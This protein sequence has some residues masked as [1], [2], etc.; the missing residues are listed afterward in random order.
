M[1]DLFL[2]SFHTLSHGLVGYVVP[3]LFV[4]TIVVFFHELG[5]FLVAR[6]NGVKV[7]TFSIGFGPEIVGFNDRYGTRWKL[8]AVPLGGYVKFFGD[9]SEASTPSGDALSQM[10]ASERAVSFHHKPVGPRAAIV[11]AGPLANFILAVVLFTFLFSVFG[12]PNT[13][14]R[15]DGVQPGS[16]AEA[17]GFKPGD[18]VTSINGSAISN[19]LEM[20][21]FVGA[22][23]GNQLKFTVKRGDSTVDLVATPQLKEIKDRFG[24]V[25][26]LGILGIS[27]ST[28]AGEVT[29]EQVNPAVAFWMGIKE[30]WFVVDRTFSYIGGIFTGR[31]AADQLGGPL[32]IA[33]VSGQV[34]TIGFTPLLHL[35]AVLS[36]SIGLLNLFPV[37]LLDG[38]HLLFYGIE[39]ARG[40]PLSERAQELG[41]RIGLALVL[42]LMMFATYNDILHLA[43]S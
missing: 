30:T 22:E 6:W 24:N 34:A 40:R 18:V 43:S 39:A 19:F 32:R 36:I 17:A 12:V 33:Q 26:R 5:H 1:A 3:F 31:E 37:P 35:A 8:S 21:R 16:A 38:G 42:M 25:Q 14:A 9:D 29:T 10:S 7:L 15:V 41:F 13:S 23:A 4:L 2:N 11:V 27:R 20:Q 28:A